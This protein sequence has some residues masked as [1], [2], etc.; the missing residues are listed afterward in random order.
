MISQHRESAHNN[1]DTPF[2]FTPANQ[3][4]VQE[5]LAR[6]PTNYKAVRLPRVCT[7]KSSRTVSCDS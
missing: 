6:Y 1:K 3:K 2:E 4:K 5:I 7:C